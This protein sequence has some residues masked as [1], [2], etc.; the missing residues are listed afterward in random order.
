[1]PQLAALP[2]PYALALIEASSLPAQR[3]KKMTELLS[4]QGQQ[5]DPEALAMQKRAGE[6]EIA[7]KE[8]EVGLKQAQAQKLLMPEPPKQVD[9]LEAQ[10]KTGEL[11]LQAREL[12]LKER[13]LSLKE[14]ELM[15]KAEEVSANE[16]LEMARMDQE[17]TARRD[18]SQREERESLRE[19]GFSVPAGEDTSGVNLAD[20]MSGLASSLAGLGDGMR[21]LADAQAKPKRVVRDPSTGRVVGTE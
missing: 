16:R 9:P 10:I 17:T 2:P 8:A 18:V 20:V 6:A 19:K 12:D 15:V 11:Q 13:E 1:M 21:A 7:G 5:Q 4:G 14:R 3:K